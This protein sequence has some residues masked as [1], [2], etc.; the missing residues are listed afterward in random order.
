MKYFYQRYAYFMSML[1]RQFGSDAGRDN[2]HL[3]SLVSG[4]YQQL[5]PRTN[6]VNLQAELVILHQI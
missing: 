3:T 1:A 5:E 2:K 4:K 6:T